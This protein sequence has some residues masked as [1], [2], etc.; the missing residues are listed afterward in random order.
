MYDADSFSSFW[1]VELCHNYRDI[2][3]NDKSRLITL[4][5]RAWNSPPLRA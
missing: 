3:S 1:Y 5:L 4:L 2:R